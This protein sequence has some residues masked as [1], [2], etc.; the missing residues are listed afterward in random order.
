VRHSR[1]S[2]STVLGV[3]CSVGAAAV[4]V[5]EATVLDWECACKIAARCCRCAVPS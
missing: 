3:S 4:A 5:A 1:L 2:V